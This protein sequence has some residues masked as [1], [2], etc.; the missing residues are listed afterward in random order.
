MV[1][2]LNLTI[3]CD[4]SSHYALSFGEVSL[5]LLEQFFSYYSDLIL[6]AI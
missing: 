1:Y 5:T 3:V 6:G 2:L 4:S